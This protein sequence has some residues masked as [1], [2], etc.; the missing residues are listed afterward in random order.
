M[1]QAIV[2]FDE[3]EE[4]TIMKYSKLWNISKHETVKRI[5]REY[6]KDEG[7]PL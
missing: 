3:E 7:D 6:G 5:M 2:Y 1:P 4:N